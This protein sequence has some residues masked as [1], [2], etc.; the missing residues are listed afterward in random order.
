MYFF[1]CQKDRRVSISR[2]ADPGIYLRSASWP[3]DNFPT[4][5]GVWGPPLLG[6]VPEIF[7]PLLLRALK[8]TF[9]LLNRSGSHLRMGFDS[10][11][12][13]LELPL[14]VEISGEFHLD[15]CPFSIV[16]ISCIPQITDPLIQEASR[17]LIDK[18][19]VCGSRSH[20]GR[21]VRME[22]QLCCVST[23]VRAHTISE[24]SCVPVSR[25]VYLSLR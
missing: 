12:N 1:Q 14:K 17:S 18:P 10:C 13:I 8:E 19:R 15:V 22:A 5:C 11:L 21:A 3:P 2:H 7:P 4:L 16:S 6:Q 25:G 23:L 9:L 24:N 20:P